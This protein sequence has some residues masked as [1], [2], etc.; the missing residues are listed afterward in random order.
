VLR[1]KS[2]WGLG[3]KPLRLSQIGIVSD[4]HNKLFI[5]KRIKIQIIL[6]LLL[7]G[8]VSCNDENDIDTEKPLISTEFAGSF[9]NNCDTL[10]F[11]E[12]SVVKIKFTDN[13]GLGS[14][15]IAIH[16]NFDHHS[17]STEVSACEPQ[18]KKEP[19]SPYTYIG[20]FEIPAGQNEYETNLVIS[21][22]AGNGTQFFDEGDYHF[23][24]SLTDHEGWSSQMG[25]S[26]KMMHRKESGN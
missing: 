19:V 2:N 22:P 18:P 16:H 10:Y 14:Y 9:P 17:H 25:L 15:S 20:D 26:I 13:V 11:G 1:Q 23:F 4:T 21:I 5:M 12:S 24:I 8:V 7:S 3:A 6:I